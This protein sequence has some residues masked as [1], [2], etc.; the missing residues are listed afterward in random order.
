MIQGQRDEHDAMCPRCGARGEW[1]LIDEKKSTVEILCPNC[2]S[3]EMTR[4]EF[5]SAMNETAGIAGPQ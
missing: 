2:G 3:L 4:E 1:S 5:D